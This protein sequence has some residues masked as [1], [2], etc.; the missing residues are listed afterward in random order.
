MLDVARERRLSTA[1]GRPVPSPW[2]PLCI[3]PFERGGKWL[4]ERGCVVAEVGFVAVKK[5]WLIAV[6]RAVAA[7]GPFARKCRG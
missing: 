6:P 2:E 4:G 1:L 7:L 3:S 5:V